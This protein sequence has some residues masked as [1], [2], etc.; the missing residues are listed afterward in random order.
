MKERGRVLKSFIKGS[1]MKR[2]FSEV[3]T[4]LS[5][6]A[7]SGQVLRDEHQQ[8]NVAILCWKDWEKE[9]FAGT[10]ADLQ[11]RENGCLNRRW[12]YRLENTAAAKTVA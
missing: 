7:R 5:E 10:Q 12:I 9:G 8:D 2:L 6:V 4:L 1:F 11:Q 3:W